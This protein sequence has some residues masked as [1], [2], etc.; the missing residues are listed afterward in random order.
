MAL[1]DS[2]TIALTRGVPVT[3]FEETVP[4]NLPGI[5]GGKVNLNDLPLAADEIRILLEVKYSSGGSFEQA[6]ET[7][8]KKPIKIF[9]ITPAEEVFGYKLTIELVAASPSPSATLGFVIT[10]NNS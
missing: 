3:L 5:F 4:A 9:R 8:Y 1:R 10:R 7:N 6:E 2:G